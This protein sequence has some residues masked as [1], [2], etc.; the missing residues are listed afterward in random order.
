MATEEKKSLRWLAII[1]RRCNDTTSGNRAVQI[2]L[3]I[4]R[5]DGIINICE[6]KFSSGEFSIDK[7][8]AEDLRE[9]IAAFTR[10]NKVRQ[11]CHITMITTYG[12]KQGKYS[13]MVQSEVILD[14]FF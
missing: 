3:L 7:G 6:C 2:D 10:E 8:L 9:R 5:T 1:A 11:A 12:I 4:R 13:N 14:E